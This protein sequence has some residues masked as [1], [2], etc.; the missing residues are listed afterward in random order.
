LV[1]DRRGR[2]AARVIGRVDASTLLSLVEDA[3]ARPAA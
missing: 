1:L 3:A 2:V